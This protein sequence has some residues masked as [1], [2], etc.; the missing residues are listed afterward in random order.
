MADLVLGIG[1]AHTPQLHTR[2]QDW[3]IRAE[4]DRTNG[5]ELWWRGKRW[6]WDDLAEARKSEGLVQSELDSQAQRRLDRC[7]AAVDKLVEKYNEVRPDVAIICGNDQHELF[8]DQ[9]QPAFTVI[10]AEVIENMPRTEDMK[11]RLPPGIEISDHGHLPDESMSFRGHPGLASHVSAALSEA[12]FDVAYSRKV[13]RPDEDKAT[14]G[15]MPHAYGFI[16]RNIMLDNPIPHVPVVLNSFFPPNRPSA[17]RVYD[18][19]C[20]VGQAIQAWETDARV[21]VVASGGLS[22][23]AIDEEFDR[24]F[25]QALQEKDLSYFFLITTMAKH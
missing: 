18:F 7:F 25:L 24:K 20:V 17:R 19:G 6:L 1:C 3:A 11:S 16:Y 10:G 8:L 4:R 2:A 14:V 21:M 15:G 13:P 9:I 23:F 12:D 5:I 22:H